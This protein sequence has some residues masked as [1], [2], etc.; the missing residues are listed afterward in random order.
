[1]LY[2]TLRD[3]T[4]VNAGGLSFFESQSVDHESQPL[5]SMS[6]FY[7]YSL[8]ASSPS[9][10]LRWGIQEEAGCCLIKKRHSSSNVF[11]N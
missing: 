11:L 7:S 9:G 10:S 5:H 4:L 8:A 1:M 6:E 3:F 2:L